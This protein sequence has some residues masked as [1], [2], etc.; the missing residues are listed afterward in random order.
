MTAR[1]VHLPQDVSYDLSCGAVGGGGGGVDRA[2]VRP[3]DVFNNEGKLRPLADV[4]DVKAG[5]VVLGKGGEIAPLDL[6]DVSAVRLAE[7]NMGLEGYVSCGC[8]RESVGA[9]KVEAE[10]V[11]LRNGRWA[12]STKPAGRNLK[13]DVPQGNYSHVRANEETHI[14][15]RFSADTRPLSP[16]VRQAASWQKI[17]PRRRWRLRKDINDA[18]AAHGDASSPDIRS[19]RSTAS[20]QQRMRRGPAAETT[21][22][23]ASRT[24]RG[25][26]TGINIAAS[27]GV[28]TQYSIFF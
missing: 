27:L 23:D 3:C 5:M 1:D 4:V 18:P 8:D 17:G 25:R 2:G 28:T 9:G 13:T 21:G 11:R 7:E 26:D 15:C 14:I 20:G 10:E 12:V 22:K 24:V 6:G 19:R 16:R